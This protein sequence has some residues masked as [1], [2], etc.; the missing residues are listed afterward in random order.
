MIVDKNRIF[1]GWRTLEGGVDG[2]RQPNTI[3]PNQCASAI[4]MTFRGGSATTR[5]I[6]ETD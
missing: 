6:Q 3:D 2:G 1:D 4:N 5:P